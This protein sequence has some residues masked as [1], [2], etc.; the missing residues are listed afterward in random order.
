MQ[1]RANASRTIARPQFRELIFQTFYDPETNRQFNGNPL[2]I[3]SELTNYEVRGEYYLGG[4]DRISVAAFYKDIEDPIEA[5]SS[6]SDNNQLTSFANAPSATLYGVEADVAYTISLMDWGGWFESKDLSIFANYTWTNSEIAVDAADTTLLFPS[7]V[8]PATNLFRDGVPLTGQSDHLAN[9]QVSLED[10]DTLQQFTVLLNYASE[11]VTSR[12]TSGL[13][14]IVEDPGL[15]VDLVFRQGIDLFGSEAEFKFEA[16]NI[17]GRGNEEFQT[18]GI[19]RF[20][21]NTFDVGTTIAGSLSLT[22]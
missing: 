3:D 11:R 5:F 14:D 20:E 9:F 12:G 18:N 19:D 2:L 10:I 21:I 6:F 15:R 16:R 4:G 13:P 17:F 1:L 8:T 7:G 22:F